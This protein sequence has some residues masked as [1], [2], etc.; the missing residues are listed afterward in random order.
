MVGGRNVATS[1][2]AGRAVSRTS[3]RLRERPR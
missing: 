1:G 3:W 2:A